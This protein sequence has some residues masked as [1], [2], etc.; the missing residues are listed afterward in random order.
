VLSDY[1]GNFIKRIRTCNTRGVPAPWEGDRMFTSPSPLTRREALLATIALV[2]TLALSSIVLSDPR[3]PSR[4]L[5]H[6]PFTVEVALTNLH[7]V[8]ADHLSNARYIDLTHTIRPNMLI[9]SWN[10]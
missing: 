2:N 1:E 9:N 6:V 5:L 8:Y 7:R 3:D 4:L 10:C